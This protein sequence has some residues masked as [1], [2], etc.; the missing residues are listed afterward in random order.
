MVR[1]SALALCAL[2]LP[3]CSEALDAC[4]DVIKAELRSPATYERVES[5]VYRF[6]QEEPPYISV[7]V[8]YDAANAY[9]TPIRSLAVCTIPI[10]DG[11][12][13]IESISTS[14][15]ERRQY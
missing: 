15:L 11:Q 14:G 6:E 5:N 2:A 13:D 3:G 8:R 4:E 10:K 1:S 7:T 12:A 9:G